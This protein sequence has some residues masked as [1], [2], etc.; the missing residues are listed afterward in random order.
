MPKNKPLIEFPC[1]F[2]IKVM[3]INSSALIADVTAIVAVHCPDFD[4]EDNIKITPSSKG[5]YISVTATVNATSQQ[6]LDSIY[7][8]L[9]KHELVKFTL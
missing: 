4:P 6:Q 5:N 9:S 1:T 2:P 3:G 7:S 8:D